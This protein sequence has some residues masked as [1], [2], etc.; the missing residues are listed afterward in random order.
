VNPVRDHGNYLLKMQMEDYPLGT[1]IVNSRC[2]YKTQLG[3][4]ELSVE[5]AD[6]RLSVGDRNCQFK[7]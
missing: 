4:R 1:G 2:E 5:V 6:G 7:M 3:T